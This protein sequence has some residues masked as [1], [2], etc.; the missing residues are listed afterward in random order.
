MNTLVFFG[1]ERL[2]TGVNTEAP[3]LQ[4]LIA[5]GYKIAAVVSSYEPGQSRNARSL[6]IE[7]IAKHHNIPVLLPKKMVGIVDKLRN[8]NATAAVL[9]AYGKIV[10]QS[11]IDLFP[12]GI[13]NLHPSLLPLHRGPTPIE[14]AILHGDE[15][16]GVSLM[17]LVKSMDAGPVYAQ[18]EVRLKGD[19]SKQQLAD[20]LLEVGGLMLLDLLPGILD[21]SIV[22]VPQDENKATYDQLISKD[23]GIIDWSKPAYIL[24]RE[25]RAFLVWPKSSATLMGKEVIITAAHIVAASGP[26]GKAE[27]RNKELLVYCGKEALS[28]DRLKPAGKKEMTAAAFLAGYGHLFKV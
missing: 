16:T 13:I 28:I 2:A 14:G 21:K 9:V 18:S 4:A 3:T 7:A 26:P 11:I 1:N 24:E 5:S 10:P 20:T 12:Y 19:E 17:Q 22:A 25:I 8:Y 23:Q 6:E 27:I 15:K